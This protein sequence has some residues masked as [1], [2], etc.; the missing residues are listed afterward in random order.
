MFC[1]FYWNWRGC[2]YV[3]VWGMRITQKG[4]DQIG[5]TFFIFVWLRQ[6]YLSRRIDHENHW[7][8]RSVSRSSEKRWPQNSFTF[9]VNRLE[10]YKNV[11]TWTGGIWF[12]WTFF[13]LCID[14]SCRWQAT[15]TQIVLFMATF[16]GC[17]DCRQCLVFLLYLAGYQKLI[18]N[19]Y[20]KQCKSLFWLD[21]ILIR[22][23]YAGNLFT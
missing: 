8:S 10:K 21:I 6:G 7:P 3:T 11:V 17:I 5:W 20:V 18:T 12:A 9:K 2:L 4:I 16:W 19:Q 13:V 22:F 14:N 15:L 1:I 23:R